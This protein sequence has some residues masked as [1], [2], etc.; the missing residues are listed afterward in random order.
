MASTAYV[1]HP[2]KQFESVTVPKRHVNT[3]QNQRIRFHFA[4]L[5]GSDTFPGLHNVFT[6]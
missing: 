3:E 6:E 2:S 5:Y 4:R 1:L